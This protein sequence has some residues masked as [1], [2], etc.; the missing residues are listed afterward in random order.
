MASVGRAIK[1]AGLVTP[2]VPLTVTVNFPDGSSVVYQFNWNLKRFEYV[3]G[4]ARDSNGNNIP[5]SLSDFVNGGVGRGEFDFSRSG[6]DSRDLENFLERAMS[7]GVKV[8]G[9]GVR[10]GCVTTTS[11]TVCTRMN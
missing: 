3:P 10:I 2:D 1:L 11:G 5:E 9:N 7:L 4:T 6:P 8:I